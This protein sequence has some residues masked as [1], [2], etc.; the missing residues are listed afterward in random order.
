MHIYECQRRISRQ[1]A[2]HHSASFHAIYTIPEIGRGSLGLYIEEI[3]RQRGE[4]R[5]TLRE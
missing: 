2:A 1:R 3:R 5:Y 4:G